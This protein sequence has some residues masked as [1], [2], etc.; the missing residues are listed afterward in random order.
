MYQLVI[1]PTLA[2][3]PE[4]VNVSVCAIKSRK[5]I[6]GGKKAEPKEF[7][8]M[9]AVGYNNGDSIIFSCGGSLISEKFVLTAA[10]CFFSIEWGA[11]SWVRVGDL[12]LDRTDDRAEPQ[13]VRIIKRIRHPE[14]QRPPQYHD[15]GLLELE[16][17]VTFGAWVRPICLPYSSPD[18]GNERVATAAGWGK[19]DWDDEVGSS[20]MLKVTIQL[21]D[22]TRCNRSIRDD[23]VAPRGI[24]DNWQICAGEPGK[25]TCQ[26]DSGGPLVI[27]NQDYKCM[28]SIVG[29]TSFGGHCGSIIPGVYT[30]VSNYIPWIV[31]TIWPNLL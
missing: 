10:H 27:L 16:S 6:V 20:D 28:Y 4:P 12:N 31:K 30:R 5:L 14:Y 26:G 8:H 21:V 15:I 7:P 18:T 1:P 2:I 17:A 11:A 29:I 9:A 19:V 13:Q 23:R 25:D 3:D 24:I 22:N